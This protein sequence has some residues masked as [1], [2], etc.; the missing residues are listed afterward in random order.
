[1]AQLSTGKSLHVVGQVNAST[2]YTCS[3]CLACAGACPTGALTVGLG[4][5]RL[6][7]EVAGAER[8]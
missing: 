4:G 1:V 6:L 8:R 3:R 5:S 2:D 7:H